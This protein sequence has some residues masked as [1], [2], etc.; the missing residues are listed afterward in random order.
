[1]NNPLFGKA[2]SLGL[3]GAAL[4][5]KREPRLEIYEDHKL[6]KNKWR[7][8]IFMSSDEVAASTQGYATEN[9]CKENLKS[10][11]KYIASLEQSDK[12]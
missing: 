1:M 3:L 4:T 12:I 9:L 7:W 2:G 8:R 11:G 5:L 10:V 6:P